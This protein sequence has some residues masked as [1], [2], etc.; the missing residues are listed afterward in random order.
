MLSECLGEARLVPVVTIWGVLLA[1]VRFPGRAGG[2]GRQRRRLTLLCLASL[3]YSVEVR[4]SCSLLQE[5]SAQS[6]KGHGLSPAQG[7]L[8]TWATAAFAQTVFYLCLV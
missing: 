8:R 1:S 6:G 2:K 5:G 7:T 4:R 3:R